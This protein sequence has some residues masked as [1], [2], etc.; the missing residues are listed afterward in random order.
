MALICVSRESNPLTPLTSISKSPLHDKVVLDLDPHRVDFFA[1]AK[2]SK[3][4]QSQMV[5]PSKELP[6]SAAV[7][8]LF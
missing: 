8:V 2:I 4:L 1:M 6:D 7:F 5:A 3:L